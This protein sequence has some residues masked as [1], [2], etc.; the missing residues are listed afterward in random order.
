MVSWE[1]DFG[2]MSAATIAKKLKHAELHFQDF[3]FIDAKSAFA[4]VSN[5][6]VRTP[7][8]SQLFYDVKAL[9]DNILRGRVSRLHWVDTIDMLADALT[10]GKISPEARQV[11]AYKA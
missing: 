10:K 3:M 2:A 8:E 4:A 6:A 1:A 9:Q 5:P 7:T 11:D